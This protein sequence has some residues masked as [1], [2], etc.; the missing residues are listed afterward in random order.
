MD[1]LENLS[2]SVILI[3]AVL[4]F[5]TALLHLTRKKINR[6]RI[7][8]VVRDCIV[9]LQTIQL[10]FLA[11][12]LQI[13]YPYLLYPLI[14]LLFITG[15]LNYIRYFMLLVP[16]GRIPRKVIIQLIPAGIIFV[17]ETSIYFFNTNNSQTMMRNFFEKPTA[18][19]ITY[20]IVIG[21]VVSLIQYWQ[22]LRLE[23]G[24]IKRKETRN[25]VLLSSLIMILYMINTL[26]IAYGFLFTNQVIK[27]TGILLIGVTG[28]TYLLHENRYPDFYQLV[29]REERQIKY[30]KSLIRGLSK[31][32]IIDRL[33]ELMGVDR[34]YQQLDL[35]LEDVAAMLMITPHQ[36]SE[37]INDY[38]GMNFTSFI[39][40]YRVEEAKMLLVDN[41]DQSTLSIG[42]QV[43]FG[44]KQSFNTIFKQQT[45]LTP[46]GYRKNFL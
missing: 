41:P 28:I 42:F 14:T 24:F 18:F 1:L 22:V 35:K 34:V 44:S 30:K 6:S 33:K 43:G 45:G 36:L 46:S 3:A 12:N 13:Q 38:M 7:F 37:F 17:W 21:V 20:V 25:P 39:N 16:G 32:K 11:K 26:L 31:D 19:L 40:Q 2:A 10:Y 23:F 8:R 29:A 5:Y 4:T 27:L 9:G 15:P